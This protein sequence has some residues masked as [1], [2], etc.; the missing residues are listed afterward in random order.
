M[1]LHRS[2]KYSKIGSYG[3]GALLLI[4]VAVILRVVLV[5]NGWPP[6]NS[7]EAITGLQALHILTRGERPLFSYGI[8]Y[9]GTIQ[10]YLGAFFF[11]LFGPSIFAL[12]LGL[13][14]LYAGFLLA[15]YLLARLLYTKGI[16]LATVFFLCWGSYYTLDEQL[17]A[18]RGTLEILLFA[19]LS[20]LL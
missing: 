4:S 17:W 9:L 19:T 2:S 1:S 6:I 5:S 12:R 16:A 7:D 3:L 15:L 8:P 18:Y 10:S 11:L 20:F 14:A 13:V